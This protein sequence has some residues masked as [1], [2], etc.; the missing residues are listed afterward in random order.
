MDHNISYLVLPFLPFLKHFS[1]PPPPQRET[2]RK[3][4]ATL[5]IVDWRNRCQTCSLSLLEFSPSLCRFRS[6][7]VCWVWVCSL[8]LGWG[9]AFVGCGALWIWWCVCWGEELK[10]KWILSF[11]FVLWKLESLRLKFHVFPHVPFFH[12]KLPT[13][14][15]RVFETRFATLYSSLWNSRC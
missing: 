2:E 8:W 14:R 10:V 11:G 12:I 3:R 6:E 4:E 13:H 5:L 9:G 15:T 1:F 7:W